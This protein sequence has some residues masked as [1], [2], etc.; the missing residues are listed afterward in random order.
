MQRDNKNT[1]NLTQ[2]AKEEKLIFEV[3][4]YAAVAEL[5]VDLEKASLFYACGFTRKCKLLFLLGSLELNC[6]V[7]ILV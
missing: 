5:L 6:R 4:D 3:V 1:N 2:A 7:V